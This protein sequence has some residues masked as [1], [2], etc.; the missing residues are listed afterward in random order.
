[1]A[2]M[3]SG[4]KSDELLRLRRLESGMHQESRIAVSDGDD[5]GHADPQ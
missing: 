1:M 2:N 3:A 5:F 4:A